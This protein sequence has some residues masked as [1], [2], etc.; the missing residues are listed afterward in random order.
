MQGHGFNPQSGAES[1]M[2]Q[3]MANKQANEQK[4]EAVRSRKSVQRRRGEGGKGRREGKA[5]AWRNCQSE[6]REDV[7]EPAKEAWRG[8]SWWAGQPGGR[9]RKCSRRV[10]ICIVLQKLSEEC[11]GDGSSW[12][13]SRL[14]VILTRAVWVSGEGPSHFCRS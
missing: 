4:T 6:I 8:R 10:T 1:C 2:S 13:T 7:M 11:S 14:S 9:W 5:W 3:N 12:T